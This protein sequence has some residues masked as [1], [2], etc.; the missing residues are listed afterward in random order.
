VFVPEKLVVSFKPGQSMLERV[1]GRGQMPAVVG[2][3]TSPT[4]GQAAR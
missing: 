2:A 1:Q 3:G 4:G